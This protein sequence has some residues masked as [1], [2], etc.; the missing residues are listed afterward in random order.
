VIESLALHRT[1][2]TTLLRWLRRLAVATG[3]LVTLLVV[4]Q[5]VPYGR[6]HTNPAVVQE[7]TWDSPRTRE[8]AR[9]ACFDCHSNETTWPWYA[10][11]APMSWVVQRD[12]EVGRSVLNFSEWHRTY[13]LNEQAGSEVI[14]R[15][16][17][18]RGYKLLHGHAHLTDGEVAELARGLHA[19]FGLPWRE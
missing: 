19:T 3:A 12:V 2:M 13:D 11:V 1:S 5:L 6:A 7:P 17:P 15:E 18:P 16:M 10:D 9:R 14:R 4:M 8:L